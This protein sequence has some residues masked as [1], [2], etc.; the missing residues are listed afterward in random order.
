MDV[1]LGHLEDF[2]V[3]AA[4]RHFG[5]AAA[6]RNLSASALSKRVRRLEH[7]V[8]V[9]LVERGGGGFLDLTPAGRCFL[10]RAE[11]LLRNADRARREARSA[12][13]TPVVRLGIPGAPTDHLSP[14]AWQALVESVARTFP[15]CRVLAVGVPYGRLTQSVL[16][17]HVDVLLSTGDLDRP[18][19]DTVPLTAVDRVC[20]LP[21]DHP[22]AGAD[23][24]TVADVV[25]LPMIVEP[26]AAPQWM[27]PWVL[28][29][30][31]GRRGMR[32]TEVRAR[33]LADVVASVRSGAAVTLATS[34]LVPLL[35]PALSAPLV[36]D[37]PLIEIAA[38]HRTGDDRDQVLALLDVLRILSPVIGCGRR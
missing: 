33:T 4:E 6:R 17:G 24:V 22:L 37:A 18:G 38:M 34:T 29:D 35:P 12:S 5:R 21:S 26:T 1:N 3:L 23:A 36:A 16:A 20:L 9:R 8:G 7:E 13:G 31:R 10:P 11:A 27:S 2:R 14:A 25:D 28:G 15:D 32:L 30:V 19:L